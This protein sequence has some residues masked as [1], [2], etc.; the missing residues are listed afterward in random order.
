MPK[1]KITP[2]MNPTKV[3]RDARRYLI[4]NGWCQGR[5]T[6]GRVRCALSAIET[7]H[8]GVESTHEDCVRLAAEPYNRLIRA[9]GYHDIISWNDAKGRTFAE[10]SAALR[11]RSKG[12]QKIFDDNPTRDRRGRDCERMSDDG[13]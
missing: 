6:D 2:P 10:V 5:W 13:H 9:V 1:L 11:A 3:L 8:P 7:V 4:T 12:R